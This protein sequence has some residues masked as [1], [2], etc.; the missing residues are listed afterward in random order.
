LAC[1]A[2]PDFYAAEEFLP[3]GSGETRLALRLYEAKS[4]IGCA[5]TQPN[6]LQLDGCS[7][8]REERGAAAGS[9]HAKR[10]LTNR[11]QGSHE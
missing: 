7:R 4:R 1:A 5:L 3:P 2:G 10:P 8:A 9:S 6:K 11:E